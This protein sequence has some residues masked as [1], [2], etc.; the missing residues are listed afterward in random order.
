[1]GAGVG[2]IFAYFGRSLFWIGDGDLVFNGAKPTGTPGG[3]TTLRFRLYQSGGYNGTTF[4]AGLAAPSAPV[5]VTAGAAG[6]KLAGTYSV[7]LTAIRSTTGAESNASPQSAVI[8]ISGTKLRVKFPA[9]VGNGQDKWGVYVTAANFGERGPHLSLPTTL[10][11][12]SPAGFVTEATVAAST[13]GGAGQR[14][15]DFEWASGD[16]I[17]GNL[18]PID[19]FPPP[20]GVFAFPIEG[21][22]AVAGAYAGQ[23]AVTSDN[24]GNMIAVSKAGFPEAFPIDAD[25]LITLPEP[26]TLVLPRAANGFVY[27][28]GKNSLSAVRYTGTNSKAPLALAVLWPDTGFERTGNACLADGVLY[29][30]TAIKGFVRIDSEG[31]P[32][33]SFGAPVHNEFAGIPSSAVR[34]GYDP[35]SNHVVYGYTSGGVSRLL[36]YNKSYGV[37]SA[38]IKFEELVSVPAGSPAIIISMYTNGGKLFIILDTGGADYT[39]YEFNSGTGSKWKLRSS[40]RDGGTPGKNKTLTVL[41]AATENNNATVPTTLKVYKNLSETV[42]ETHAPT[43]SGVS[44]HLI[45]KRVNVRNAKTYSVELSGT[46]DDTVAIEA[47][48]EGVVSEVDT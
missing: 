37:W 3:T 31:N 23:D 12:E 21:C 47:S 44:E 2:S 24:V 27:V 34:C 8:T 32:D 45:V 13:L 48:L 19:H 5:S 10:T 46:D 33:Y 39:I 36:C 41:H 9:A 17:S 26:P 20:V 40:W 6:T 1:M 28:A 11:G 15:L 42:V 16:L 7:R 35:T 38:P 25:H 18:A 29:G 30:Y 43:A 4:T 22:I 14:N